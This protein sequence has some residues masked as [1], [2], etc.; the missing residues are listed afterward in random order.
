MPT[1]DKKEKEKMN[2]HCKRRIKKIIVDIE[3]PFTSDN[4]KSEMITRHGTAYAPS[5]I[6]LGQYLNKICVV[7]GKHRGR[8]L[9][10]VR[11]N[12]N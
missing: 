7:V 3:Q 4:I 11:I 5:N 10:K 12:E 1:K 2:K 6:S 8:F 9:Y